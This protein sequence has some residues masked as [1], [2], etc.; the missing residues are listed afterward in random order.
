MVFVTRTVVG[1]PACRTVPMCRPV[2]SRPYYTPTYSYNYGPTYR[3]S[4]F[5]SAP[6]CRPTYSY[7]SWNSAYHVRPV[8]PSNGGVAGTMAVIGTAL[9]LGS[10]LAL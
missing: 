3:G 5:G 8:C 6:Y 9:L 2:V 7:P 10:I 1:G 4:F